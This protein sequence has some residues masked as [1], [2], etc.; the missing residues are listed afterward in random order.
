MLRVTFTNDSALPIAAGA[1]A[2]VRADNPA[3]ELA[4]S[5]FQLPAIEPRRSHTL[6]IP[7]IAR[8]DGDALSSALTVEFKNARRLGILRETVRYP[9]ANAYR[10]RLLSTPNLAGL[11]QAGTFRLEYEITKMS[12][13]EARP[14]ALQ[15][16]VRGVGAARER[17]RV[18]TGADGAVYLPPLKRGQAFKFVVPVNVTTA[19][20]GGELEFEL[21]AA[22]Q[23][24]IIRRAKF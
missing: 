10:V 24:V 17:L 5:E 3:L 20:D 7:V 15:I 19:N 1:N 8:A 9:V 18:A 2:Q 4:Q 6:E 22:G 12:A 14:A 13:D 11:H 21:Q 16:M 23:P